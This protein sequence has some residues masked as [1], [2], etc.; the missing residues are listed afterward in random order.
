MEVDIYFENIAISHIGYEIVVRPGVAF[1]LQIQS[2]L[3]R[4]NYEWFVNNDEVIEFETDDD[5][6]LIVEAKKTG[7]AKV[8]L[9]TGS[10]KLREFQIYVCDEADHYLKKELIADDL[11]LTASVEMK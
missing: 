8:V 4:D 7:N 3:H 9:T 6:S 11:G 1:A 2:A 10:A 5:N